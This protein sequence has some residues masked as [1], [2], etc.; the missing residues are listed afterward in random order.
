MFTRDMLKP[1][2]FCKCRNGGVFVVVENER[3][4]DVTGGD[5]GY[6][7][8]CYDLTD[9]LTDDITNTYGKK[10]Y[11]VVAISHTF[12]FASPIWERDVKEEERE[13]IRQ[14]IAEI[15]ASLKA[16]K[17]ALENI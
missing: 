17:E 12:D 14:E 5:A 11:D 2:M 8:G 16:K 13:K 9:A 7:Y 15:E 10:E 6:G 4:V 3:I 1:G